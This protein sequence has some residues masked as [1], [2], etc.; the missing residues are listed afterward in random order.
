MRGSIVEAG[1][2]RLDGQ[3]IA[4]P[5]IAIGTKISRPWSREAHPAPRI[6]GESCVRGAPAVVA[7]VL[8]AGGWDEVMVVEA[9]RGR[10]TSPE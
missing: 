6:G 9:F 5:R 7:A 3:L 2:L 8:G 4:E 10:R 1:S